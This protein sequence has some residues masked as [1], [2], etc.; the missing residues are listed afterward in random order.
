MNLLVDRI[1][2]AMYISI[3]FAGF[4]YIA[5]TFRLIFIKEKSETLKIF[6]TIGLGLF[7]AGGL[8]VVMLGF[9]FLA[10]PGQV[11]AQKNIGLVISQP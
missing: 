10:S 1:V 6:K 11:D 4:L 5:Y 9:V 7:A 2:G 8:T 3:L